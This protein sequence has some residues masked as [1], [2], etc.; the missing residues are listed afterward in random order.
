[1]HVKQRCMKRNI[2]LF[3]VKIVMLFYCQLALSQN[4]A[5]ANLVW[6]LDQSTN[7][8]TQQVAD[9]SA[10]L[11]TFGTDK[12]QWIQSNGEKIA[13]YQVVSTEDIWEDVST[14]GSFIYHLIRNGQP[15]TVTLERSPSGMIATFDFTRANQAP[16]LLRF[17][18][19]S[20]QSF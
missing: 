4:I 8:Q 1:M 15:L 10:E 12:I 5:T 20:V 7:V 13:D 14:Q 6:K 19:H 17:R 11:K 18:V 16:F 3:A 9:Y 2:A